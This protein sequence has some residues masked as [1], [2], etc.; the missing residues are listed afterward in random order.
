MNAAA[1]LARATLALAQ[2]KHRAAICYAEAAV[3]SLKGAVETPTAPPLPCPAKYRSP[4]VPAGFDTV[5]GFL[6]RH[7]PQV[8]AAMDDT[9]EATQRDGFWLR[10]RCSERFILPLRVKAP[11]VLRAQ[12]IERV[13][14]YPV[15]LL[16]ERF[17]VAL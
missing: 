10:W 4:R 8:L 7:D 12:G 14:A 1:N 9:A 3:A 13:N 15:A 6:A 2:G 16:A 11:P 5:L 17:K